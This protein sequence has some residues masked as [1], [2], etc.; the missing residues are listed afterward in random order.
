[1]LITEL[2]SMVGKEVELLVGGH[3]FTGRVSAADPAS[4]TITFVDEDNSSY[5]I[6][7]GA[8]SLFK[9]I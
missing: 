3:F 5:T 7:A 6:D 1:M 9:I 2:E 8:V 4:D